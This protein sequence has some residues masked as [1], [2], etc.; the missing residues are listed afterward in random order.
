MAELSGRYMP[1]ARSFA[2]GKKWRPGGNK[3]YLEVLLALAKVPDSVVTFDKIL[4]VVPERRKPGLKAIR[5]R[6]PEVITDPERGV[7]L[8]KQLAFEPE[9]GFSIEDPLFRY[10]LSNLEFADLYRELGVEPDN[11]E[12][13]RLYSYDIGFS[14]AGESRQIVEAV[15]GQLKGE[16]VIT[17]YDY[18]QQA[19]LLA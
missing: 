6:I 15:N 1:A 17:F 3:P 18:D 7:D 11:V 5:A 2:K 19:F 8:R 10:F 9:S 16:D 13:A 14:F 12:R 4:N